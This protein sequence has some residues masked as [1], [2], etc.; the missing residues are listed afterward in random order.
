M[1]SRVTKGKPRHKKCAAD[2][3]GAAELLNFHCLRKTVCPRYNLVMR[4]A[5]CKEDKKVQELCE[6]V[7]MIVDQINHLHIPVYIS[8]SV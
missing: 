4:G 7:N 2:I 1:L 5:M 8:L 6:L 3:L